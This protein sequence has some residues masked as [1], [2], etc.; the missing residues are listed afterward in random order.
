MLLLFTKPGSLP[1]FRR[2]LPCQPLSR[3][4]AEAYMS[5]KTPKTPKPTK[6]PKLAKTPKTPAKELRAQQ[7]N[8]DGVFE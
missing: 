2:Y 1:I 5:A 6:A 3:K 8:F 7:E 4:Q